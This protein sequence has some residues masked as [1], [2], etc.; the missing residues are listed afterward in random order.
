MLKSLPETMAQ[1]LIESYFSTNGLEY[2]MGRIPIA[3]SDYSPRHYSYDDN[4]GDV[5]LTHFELQKEDI[6]YKVSNKII[7]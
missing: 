3:G 4:D 5:N 6:D 1:M 2:S 7:K